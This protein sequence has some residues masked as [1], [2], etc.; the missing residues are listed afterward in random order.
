MPNGVLPDARSVRRRC[1]RASRRDG[2][3]CATASVSQPTSIAPPSGG[4]VDDRPLPVILE[5]T[6]Y[7]K[8]ERS[9]SEIEPGD[10][11]PMTRPEVAMSLRARRLR[12]RLSRIAAA[13]TAPKA[14]FTK[15]L[16]EGEDGYDTCAW[17]VEQ[18][19]CD[20]RSAPWACPTPRIRRRRSPAS[21]RRAS[22]R[23]CSIPAASPTPIATGIRQGGAFELKQATWAY[24]NAKESPEAKRDPRSC[25]PRSRPRTSAPGSRRCRGRK[26]ARRC[27]GAPGI[28]GLSAR[29]MARTAPSMRP[30]SKVGI[31]AEGFYDKIP[32]VP[33]VLMSSWY[34]AY[35]HTTFDN[36]A[37]LKA[38][39]GKRRCRLI[40]G[41]W[42]HG[43][44]NRPSPAMPISARRRPSPA[45][46]T[47]VLA[48]VP[49]ALVRPLAEGSRQ[50]RRG[51]SRRCGCS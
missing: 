9:R 41:P 4:V 18:P 13:A 35:V 7:G 22:P 39:G 27:A 45:T 32:P 20:G 14:T 33:I 47:H 46:S 29:A 40:M 36:Y 11:E 26:G 34:D 43:N 31:Y 21:T 12:R 10:A 38:S 44:R 50:R 51:A 6:P 5:R 8:R 16:S 23:W 37:G 25:A 2:R 49:P 30:G 24:N 19:W 3:R 17:I 15:Y 1:R 48:R 28:R 42:L